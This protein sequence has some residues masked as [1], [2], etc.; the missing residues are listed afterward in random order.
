MPESR[1]LE[2][3]RHRESLLRSLSKRCFPENDLREVYITRRISVI[4]GWYS[5][6]QWVCVFTCVLFTVKWKISKMIF[7]IWEIDTTIVMHACGVCCRRIWYERMFWDEWRSL[8]CG[9]SGLKIVSKT[10][11][12]TREK[13]ISLMII[14][15]GSN[16][17]ICYRSIFLWIF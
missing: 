8:S 5:Q 9:E 12:S 11:F 6:F 1:S 3:S 7:E 2:N 17:E 14:A 13:L 16:I 15:I 4:R 10:A